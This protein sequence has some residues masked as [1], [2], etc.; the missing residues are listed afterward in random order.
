[1]LKKKVRKSAQPKT[2]KKRTLKKKPLASRAAK[3]IRHK[4]RHAKVGKVPKPAH[5]NHA[6]NLAFDQAY[7]EG[8]NAGFAQG[9]QQEQQQLAV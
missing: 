8:F 3:T 9:Y 1:M 4:R 7:N 2:K 6:Y 5:A